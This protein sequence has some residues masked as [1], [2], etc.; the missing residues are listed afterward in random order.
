MSTATDA[1]GS[2]TQ[3]VSTMNISTP[4][5][6][7]RTAHEQTR[8]TCRCTA[9]LLAFCSMRLLAVLTH[10]N[11]R[12]ITGTPFAGTEEALAAEHRSADRLTESGLSAIELPVTATDGSAQDAIAGQ[13]LEQPRSRGEDSRRINRLVI[14]LH[15]G[16]V[17]L[18]SDC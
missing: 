11:L 5:S 15:I 14:E 3:M 4:Y 6:A 16:Q 17:A 2:T 13:L 7:Q 10:S 8:L 9:D 18:G 1:R 12:T